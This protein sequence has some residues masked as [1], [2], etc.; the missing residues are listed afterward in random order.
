MRS[1]FNGAGYFCNDD[2]ASGGRLAEDDIIA[3]AHHGGAM[4]KANWKLKGGFCTVCDKPLCHAC[5]ER[6]RR[7]GCEGPQTRRLEQALTEAHRR[8][9]NARLLGI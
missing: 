8:E 2:R 4:K 6:A 3:C 7:F 9:Q 5:V 1:I